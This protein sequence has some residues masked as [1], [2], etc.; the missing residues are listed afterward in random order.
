MG[1][2][3]GEGRHRL[4]L[5]LTVRV[6]PKGGRDA[7]GGW[8]TDEAG[9]LVLNVRVSAAPADG[10]ANAAVIALIAKTLGLPRSS[11]RLVSGE[12]SRIKRLEVEDATEADLARAF[13]APP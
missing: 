5:R 13:G 11:V 6:T 12:T 9:R 3:P 8:S 7:A 4:S 2:G 10:Q 1:D